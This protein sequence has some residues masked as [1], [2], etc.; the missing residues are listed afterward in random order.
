MAAK[1][2][3]CSLPVRRRLKDGLRAS[4]PLVVSVILS[5]ITAMSWSNASNSFELS[6]SPSEASISKGSRTRSR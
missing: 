4:W 5:D 1:R 6:P 2:M 3:L